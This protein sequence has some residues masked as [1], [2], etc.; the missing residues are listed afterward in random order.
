MLMLVFTAVL[1]FKVQLQVMSNSLTL[2]DKPKL[3]VIL[4]P[5]HTRTHTGRLADRP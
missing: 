1:H 2:K 5:L 4:L 3:N